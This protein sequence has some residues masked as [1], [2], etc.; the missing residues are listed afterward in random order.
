VAR[1]RLNGVL[2]SAAACN[3]SLTNGG[4]TATWSSAPPIPTVA[5]GDTLAIVVEPD[6]AQEEIIYL[7]GPYAGGTT[8][9][10][11]QR[12]TEVTQGGQNSSAAHTNVAWVHGPTALDFNVVTA[13]GPPVTGT[14][15]AGATA[16]DATGA[17]YFCSVG[18]SPGTWIQIAGFNSTAIPPPITA[19]AI[20]ASQFPQLGLTPAAAVTEWSSISGGFSIINLGDGS[21]WMTSNTTKTIVKIVP[22][23]T[24]GALPATT[25]Y[26]LPT[27]IGG[28]GRGPDG[29]IWTA[30]SG[31]VSVIDPN[32]LAN[33]A[34]CGTT[35][36]NPVVTLADTTP[37]NGLTGVPVAGAGIPNGCYLGTIVNNTS[38]RLS[39]SPTS[40]VD[41]NATATASVTVALGVTQISVTGTG[42]AGTISAGSTLQGDQPCAGPDGR[43][44]FGAGNGM[45]AVAFTTIAGGT[46]G[47]TNPVIG[48][49]TGTTYPFAA[50][51]AWTSPITGSATSDSPTLSMT[52]ASGTNPFPTGVNGATVTDSGGAIPANTTVSSYSQSGGTWTITLSNN[53]TATLSGLTITFSNFVT[54]NAPKNATSSCVGPD[55]YIWFSENATSGPYGQIG[56]INPYTGAILEFPLYYY[57]AGAATGSFPQSNEPVGIC[58]GPDGRIWCGLNGPDRMLA[59]Q[60]SNNTFDDYKATFFNAPRYSCSG[61]DNN[62]WQAAGALNA[63]VRWF[64]DGSHQDYLGATSAFGICVGPDGNLWYCGTHVGTLPL[65]LPQQSPGGLGV[66]GDGSDG[67]PTFDGTTTI[68]GISP[69]S[70]VYTLTRDLFLASPIINSGVTIITN[71]YRIL[72]QGTLTNNGTIQWNGNNGGNGTTVGGTAGAALSG[73]N[74]SIFQGGNA[75]PAGGAGSTT[76]GAAGGNAT[77][78]GMGGAGGHGATGSN[79]GGA[80]GTVT[81]ALAI[82]GSIRSLPQAAYGQLVSSGALVSPLMGGGG[83]G[84]GGDGTNAGGGGGG[85]AAMVIVIAWQITGTGT[86]SANGGA[87]GNGNTTGNTGGGGGGGGGV[88]IVISGSVSAGAVAGQTITASGGSVGTSHGSGGASG[89]AG[90][91]GKTILIPN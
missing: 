2:G 84:G 70:S 54:T 77:V 57:V 20:A 42:P 18:G 25:S 40:Q 63:L 43:V 14:Y 5:S 52:P 13:L 29:R 61:P 27:T 10:T 22:A 12:N 35:N 69:S 34:S 16:L 87:G 47:L 65:S 89:T 9:A 23:A 72:C 39:S 45:A 36:G 1:L 8:T 81:A 11:V 44:W 21:L 62:V 4:T 48:S 64:Q 86:I 15:P 78:R 24:V 91:A 49:L 32:W 73:T 46:T 30:A 85:S 88:V 83:G 28:L 31:I 56:K 3:I 82:V 55:G 79:A 51:P 58:T 37:I 38:F 90:S 60:P 17:E 19:K 75:S 53:A 67:S 80:G 33:V 26:T 41:V 6:T 50:W 74:S 59:F 66:Y 71:G 7:P 68:L 76:T